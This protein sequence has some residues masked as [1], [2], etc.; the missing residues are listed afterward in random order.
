MFI[1]HIFMFSHCYF[2]FN[3]EVLIF[4]QIRNKLLNVTMTVKDA[5]A[6]GDYRIQRLHS[7]V[8]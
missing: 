2:K 5:Y 7:S 3:Y 8:R 1:M 4:L 6:N